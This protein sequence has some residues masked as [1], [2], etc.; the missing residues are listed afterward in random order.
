LRA[1]VGATFSGPDSNTFFPL[2]PAELR[3]ISRWNPFKR[4][5]WLQKYVVIQWLH[6]VPFAEVGRVALS[7]NIEISHTDMKW[8]LG[9]GVRAWAKGIVARIDGAFS[10]KGGQVQMMVSQPFKF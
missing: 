5:D 9:L 7:W 4:W 2:V 6:F 8:S 1:A 10:D 3:L